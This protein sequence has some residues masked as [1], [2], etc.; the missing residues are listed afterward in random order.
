MPF[1]EDLLAFLKGCRKLV[2]AGMGNNVRRDDAVGSKVVSRLKEKAPDGVE[3]IDCGTTPENFSSFFKRAE[4]THILF[5]DAV[6]MGKEPGSFGFVD[7]ETLSTQSL[8]THKQSV[9]MLFTVLREGNAN[10]RIGLVGIQPKTIEFGT[11]LSL[12]VKRGLNALMGTLIKVMGETC[13][14]D[15]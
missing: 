5:F 3:A 12:P 9:K 4:P 11:R 1:E 13:N 10:L 7:D 2:V 6:D 14:E 15:H 8:S